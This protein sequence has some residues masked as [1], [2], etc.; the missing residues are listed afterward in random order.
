MEERKAVITNIQGY[1]IHDGPGI[2]TTVFFKGCPLRCEWCANPEGLSA[3]A[4][5]GF[6]Q[7]LCKGCGKCGPACPEGAIVM[8]EGV[9]RIDREKCTDCGLC[10][11][12]CFYGAL[13][14]YG[15]ELTVRE[16][17]GKARRDKMFY[18]SSGG[19]VT[20][21]GGEPLMYADF[22]SELFGLLKAEGIGTCVET[23]GYVP[24]GSVE[25]V[26][27]VT[28]LFLYDLKLASDA[29]H[30]RFT[31]VSN[32]LILENARRLAEAGAGLLFRNPLVPGVNDNEESVS[33]IAA[34]LKEILGA[35]A[36]LELM[37]YH[38][39]GQSKYAALKLDYATETT[40]VMKAEDVDRICEEYRKRGVACTVSR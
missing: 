9:Y 31:G 2:R 23:C 12:A 10:V 17:Y 34:F 24:W 40:P 13:V 16:V 3:K 1:S 30:K 27:S 5:T 7:S 21:S 22:V 25:D 14:T 38:R 39:M 19:G 36:R 20:A 18:D 37:P 26:L 8:G 32:A 15:A 11:M 29:A 4:Q 6:L 35:E 28:D 33:G